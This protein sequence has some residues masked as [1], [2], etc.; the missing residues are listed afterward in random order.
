MS[1]IDSPCIILL[2][3][4]YFVCSRDI[5]RVTS[6]GNHI[7]NK[8]NSD[9][10][11]FAN[12]CIADIMENKLHLESYIEQLIVSLVKFDILTYLSGVLKHNFNFSH[13]KNRSGY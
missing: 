5:A 3:V 10:D 12:Q 1:L 4:M 8:F 13:F 11:P 2:I 7:V 6:T 9:L